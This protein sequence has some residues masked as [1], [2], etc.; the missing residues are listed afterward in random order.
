[1]SRTLST[2][3]AIAVGLLSIMAAC[4]DP[5]VDSIANA[6]QALQSAV[7]AGAAEYA[8]QAM[9]ATAQ[10]KAALD[11]ELAVQAERW[12]VRRSYERA[13]EL[14]AA[15]L[16]AS[17][18]AADQATHAKELARVEAT[19][20]IE[21]SRLALDEVLGML[22]VAPAGKG[23]RADLAAMKADLEAAATGL[24]E[25]AASV[26]AGQYREARSQAASARE[27]I[28]RVR[29]AIE[30]AHGMRAA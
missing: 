25:A 17:E 3:R 13:E 18:Q 30:M 7:S 6:E 8:P 21:Q 20:A 28:D 9:N 16:L 11:V 14:A 27:I 19:I 23:T 29:A 22:A 5:P 2:F 4:A 24:T 26:T 10:A 12:S 1:M 15:Y